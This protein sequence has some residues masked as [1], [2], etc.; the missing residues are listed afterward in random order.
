MDGR[1]SVRTP[2]ARKALCHELAK[3]GNRLFKDP[4]AVGGPLSADAVELLQLG[5][6]SQ[7]PKKVSQKAKKG[8]VDIL[9]CILHDG[10]WQ[11]ITK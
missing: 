4:T 1:S 5:F 2:S 11:P 9:W 6:S 3:E 7:A 8:K 10:K